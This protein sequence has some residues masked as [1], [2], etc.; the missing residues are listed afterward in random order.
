MSV[1]LITLLV[2]IATYWYSYSIHTLHEIYQ[3]YGNS[4]L[5]VVVS[6]VQNTG[7]SKYLIS[8]KLKVLELN[9]PL[10]GVLIGNEKIILDYEPISLA[11]FLRQIKFLVKIADFD[12]Y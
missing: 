12:V 4:G 10:P 5:A 6:T 2:K 9:E 7:N 11:A 1:W 3:Y 8:S